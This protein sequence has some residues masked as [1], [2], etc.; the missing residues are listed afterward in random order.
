MGFNERLLFQT[1]KPHYALFKII[2]L[3]SKQPYWF[4]YTTDAA[5]NILLF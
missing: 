4:F 3:G 1:E 2:E 5:F